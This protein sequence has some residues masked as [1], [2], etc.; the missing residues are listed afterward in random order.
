M[1]DPAVAIQTTRLANHIVVRVTGELDVF[2]AATL[3]SDIEAAIPTQAHGAV[4]D[5]T[6]V[7]FLDSTAIRKLFGLASRLAERRQRLQI[8]TPDGSTVR[9]TLQLVD[10]SRAAPM[11]VTLEDALAALETEDGEA[12]GSGSPSASGP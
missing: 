5:L 4:I 8:V 9:R 6:G 11:H 2:N 3:T 1:T 10:F 7:G 12:P